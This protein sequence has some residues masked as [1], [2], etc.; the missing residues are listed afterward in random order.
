MLK[1]FHNQQCDLAPKYKFYKCS[2][3]NLKMFSRERPAYKEEKKRK[4]KLASLKMWRKGRRLFVVACRVVGFNKCNDGLRWQW[5]K[6]SGCFHRRGLPLKF[7]ELL[8][9]EPLGTCSLV[10]SW[11]GWLVHTFLHGN[12]KCCQH[13]IGSSWKFLDQR[14]KVLAVFF[15]NLKLN[16]FFNFPHWLTS[17]TNEVNASFGVGSRLGGCRGGGWGADVVTWPR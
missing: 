11:H 2:T 8:L 13:S 9:L 12:R 6:R 15:W 5:R 4:K 10:G 16:F 17:Q 3:W 14:R 1:E 7:V